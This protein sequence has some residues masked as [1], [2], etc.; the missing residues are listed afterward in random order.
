MKYEEFIGSFN[1][2]DDDTKIA[3][4]QGYARALADEFGSPAINLLKHGLSVLGVKR[5]RFLTGTNIEKF[6]IKLTGAIIFF[7]EFK[8]ETE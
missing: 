8:H 1:G 2:K 6:A 7:T 3:I 4:L 5:V